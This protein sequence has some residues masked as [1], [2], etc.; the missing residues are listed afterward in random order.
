MHVVAVHQDQQPKDQLPKDQQMDVDLPNGL[1][2]LGVIMKTIML[3]VIGM[4]ELVVL[5][6][7][8]LI[9]M[10][11]ANQVMYVNPSD[12]QSILQ[13]FN[14]FILSEFSQNLD[15]LA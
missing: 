13:F 2:M 14:L 12:R 7:K 15:S 8:F 5:H 6:M 10:N 1:K 9:G 4:M 3:N 11:I